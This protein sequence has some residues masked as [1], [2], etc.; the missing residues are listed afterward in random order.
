MAIDVKPVAELLNY[1]FVIPN[2]QRGYRWD[3]EQVTDLL[4]DLS[5]F[6]RKANQ[7]DFYCLQPVVVVEDRQKKG[8]YIVVDG[9]QRLTTMLL[10]I[11]NLMGVDAPCFSLKFDRREEQEKFLEDALFANATDESYRRNIDNFYIRKA[12][13][14]ISDWKK[15]NPNAAIYLPTL[16]MPDPIKGYA[17]VI[18]HIIP[19]SDALKAFRRLN[20][21]KIPLTPAEL[22]KALLLQTDCYSQEEREKEQALAQRRSMEWDEMSHRLANPLFA[23]MVCRKDEEP[24]QGMD[25]VL[26]VVA[27][28]INRTLTKPLTRKAQGEK[29]RDNFVY[30]VIEEKIKEDISANSQRSEPE[31]R[32]ESVQGIWTEI[33][34]TFNML[35]DWFE[36]REW[37]HLI[38]L[39][40]LLTHRKPAR[41][42]IAEVIAMTSGPEGTARSKSDFTSSLRRHIG[43]SYIKVPKYKVI[44]EEGNSSFPDNLQGLNSPELN[45]E[46]KH[47]SSMINILTALNVMTVFNDPTGMAMFPFHLFQ[48]FNPSSLEHIHPQNITDQLSFEAAVSWLSDREKDAMEADREAWRRVANSL[49]GNK[50]NN[51]NADSNE[52]D[53]E[54]IEKARQTVA[55]SI[56]ALKSLTCD[57]TTYE[58]RNEEA[59]RHMKVLDTLFGDMAGINPEE[60][61]SISNMALVSG[62]LNSELSNKHLD[63]KR[64]ILLRAERRPES[65][66]NA[67]YVPPCTHQ[68]FAKQFRAANPGNMKFWQPEDRA[69]YMERITAVYDYFTKEI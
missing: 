19:E 29:R 53:A 51:A 35:A 25:I 18:W 26:D 44:D 6:I 58:E 36:N 60:L 10:I 56:G 22:V 46:G 50:G 42:F 32:S 69:A 8:R 2:Y 63:A 12:Y 62:K 11:K 3:E 28:K 38:G 4:N 41:E 7:S 39:L 64:Q 48:K 23:A 24:E 68:V 61:H 30:H 66:K 52:I 57:K 65:D 40:R 9:Q 21:G 59:F 43:E 45:Y 54:Q 5:S 17:A 16:F 1:E 31:K 13:D 15:L 34:E 55:E 37:Y 27:D 33:Q 67:T 14:T 49:F 20:Y 47:K